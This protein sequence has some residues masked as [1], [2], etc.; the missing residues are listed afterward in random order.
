MTSCG[1]CSV[2]T[3][4]ENTLLSPSFNDISPIASGSSFNLHNLLQDCVSTYSHR[5]SEGFSVNLGGGAIQFITV[6]EISLNI[7]VSIL[8]LPL[9]T[10]LGDLEAVSFSPGN[11]L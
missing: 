2:C 10:V 11:N 1:L 4:R 8:I 7:S 6:C 9:S 5:E 3:Q